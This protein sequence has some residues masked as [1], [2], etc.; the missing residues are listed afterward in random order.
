MLLK[1]KP[2]FLR[3]LT[4][5]LVGYALGRPLNKFDE[6]VIDDSLKALAVNDNRAGVLIEQIVLSYPFQYRYA[7]H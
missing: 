7:K 1:R 5:K 4:R 2:E 6:C 3:N